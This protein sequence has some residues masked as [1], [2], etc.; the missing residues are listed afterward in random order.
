[1][2]CCTLAVDCAEQVEETNL[3]AQREALRHAGRE[4]P[5]G[6]VQLVFSVPGI[7][8]GSCIGAIERGLAELDQVEARVNMTLKRVSVTL[9]PDHDPLKVAQH[10]SAL[11]Y[12]ATP[13]DMGDLGTLETD[14]ESRRLLRA[15]AVAGFAAANVMLLSVSVW[16]GAEGATRDLFHMISAIIAIP[17][18]AYSGQSF[19][20][21]AWGALSAKRLNMDV[22]ISLA[23][24]LALCM[25]LYEALTH[26][27]EAYF[28]AALM[29][30]FFLLIGRYLDQ[31]MRER[32]RSAV[33]GLSRIAAKGT[34]VLEDGTPTFRPVDEV[35]PGMLLLVP[36]GERIPVDGVVET[37][38]SDLDRSLVSGEAAPVAA[39][40][41]LNVEAGVL[42]I[43]APLELR[44]TKAASDSFLAEVMEMMQAAEAGRGSYTRVADRAARLYA[45]V[46]HLL[47]LVT[48]V[49]WM[50][51]GADWHSALYIGIAVLIVTCPCA[52]GLAV[53]VVHVIGA[54]RLFE[55]GILMKDGAALERLAEVDRVVFDKTGTLTTGAPLATL[56][57]LTPNEEAAA[58]ALARASTH[59]VSRAVANALPHI[60]PAELEHAEEHPGC[61]LE[62]RLNGTVLRFGRADWV[63][64]I[65]S[66]PTNTDGPAFAFAGKPARGFGLRETLR[67]GA[68]DTVATLNAQGFAPVLASGDTQAR[69][70]AMATRLNLPDWRSGMRPADKIACIRTL[71]DQGHKVLMVGDG[72]NDAPS[73]AAGDASMAPASASDVGRMAADFVFT[74]DDLGAVATALA[75][76]RKARR[77]VQ[78]NFG[79]AI[80]YNCIAVPLA[81]SGFV[82]PLIA[83]LAMSGSS[84][85]VVANSL[86]L[87]R[88]T[89]PAPRT[90]LSEVPA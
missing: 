63:A 14:R 10:L 87:A 34:M 5:D 25:S 90:T 4:L 81:V 69:V 66:T 18:A 59:P 84:I 71:Q 28:D 29:L 8:C 39:R 74:H 27:T 55:N 37:G 85:A 67:T 75:T 58:L 76:A 89:A 31:R 48:F 57:E 24:I 11:G 46:V 12:P 17:T 72:L 36:A 2:Q 19:F 13:V 88:R 35:R 9:P 47:A 40:P 56:S 43:G 1:M 83:A 23:V 26:G 3:A 78:Q 65:A 20:R 6:R 64:E 86:R 68:E 45:P 42:N 77:L 73:L 49:G 52:L 7:K 79:L 51:A 30:L 21:S 32:A 60:T 16:S 62:A 70:S 50:I 61:G 38:Q 82:T 22:P 33:I 44:A 54:G 53:P 15:L 80:L 41:G